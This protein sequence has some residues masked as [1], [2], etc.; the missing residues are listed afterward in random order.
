MSD[1][2]QEK[3]NVEPTNEIINFGGHQFKNEEEYIEFLKKIE[4]EENR[5]RDLFYKNRFAS[6]F[7]INR[8]DVMFFTY[9]KCSIREA[10]VYGYL[11]QLYFRSYY[12]KYTPVNEEFSIAGMSKALGISK[13]QVATALTRLR[14]LGLVRKEEKVPGIC[15]C[16]C[17]TIKKRF[18]DYHMVKK[19]NIEKNKHLF[20]KYLELLS[21]KEGE[22]NGK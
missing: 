13:P 16:N 11:L 20:K 17:Y 21:I 10:Y 2:N 15:D 14:K 5:K 8:F 1:V 6:S 22:E 4:I 3:L 12:S 7:L 19:E 18:T 9:H